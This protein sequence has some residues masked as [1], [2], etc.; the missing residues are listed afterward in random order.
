MRCSTLASKV[1]LVSHCLHSEC[2]QP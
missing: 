1:T 2:N